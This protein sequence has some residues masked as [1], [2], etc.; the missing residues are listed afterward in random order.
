MLIGKVEEKR[1]HIM[2]KTKVF[3][4]HMAQVQTYYTVYNV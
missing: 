3:Y 1:I 4:A 2:T